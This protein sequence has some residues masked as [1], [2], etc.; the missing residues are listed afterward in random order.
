M[1]NCISYLI[2]ISAFIFCLLLFNLA[3]GTDNGNAPIGAT[4]VMRGIS[5]M[6]LAF[7]ENMG[8]WPDSILFRANANGVTMWFT[9]TGGYH[10]FIRYLPSNGRD[11]T[12]FPIPVKFQDPD[13]R[14]SV[15]MFMVKK[16][17][18]GTNLNSVVTGK[19]LMDYKCNY[20]LGNDPAKWRTDVPNYKEIRLADVYSGIDLRFYGNGRQME[21][22][23]EVAPGADYSQ[24]Q[25]Q[26]EGAKS[27]AVNAA[28]EL[29]IKTEWGN[30]IEQV[31][32]V[33]QII[34]GKKR[35]I[36]GKYCLTSVNTFCFRLD[37]N[38]DPDFEV[39]IDPV[40]IYS[41]YLGGSGVDIIEG[42]AVDSAGC[43]YITGCTGSSDFPTHNPYNGSFNGSFDV[44]VTKLPASGS[45]LM[46]STYLGGGGNDDGYAIAVDSAGCTYLTGTTESPDFPIQNPYDGSYNC[47][48]DAFVVKL[49]VSGG[50]LV[51]STYLGGNNYD[52]CRA[53]AVDTAGC[54]YLTGVTESLDFPIQNAYD[55]IYYGIYYAFIV[56][57]SASG[58][59]LVYSTCLGGYNDGCAIA[60]DNTGCAYL[61]G[62]TQWCSDFP[63][64]NPYEGS[65]NGGYFDA[66]VTKLSA[67]GNALVYSTYL[68]GGV[69]I[70]AM[71]SR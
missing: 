60:V 7:T 5:A 43:V 30:V 55:S 18:L 65:F 24:I 36:S 42:I 14:D 49:A 21:Y 66:F 13:Q 59:E 69:M 28:G 39:V 71:A 51:Y 40:L 9:K 2:R 4:Q 25:F 57:L 53:I 23:F 12:R 1:R 68:G 31:P 33:Y 70:R 27:L 62:E 22:D 16:T 52:V 44:F 8:Q 3:L 17:L 58:G 67:S 20:F 32:I 10:Q 45:A 54:T 35:A 29:V 34:N 41:T 61:T 63:V 64:Q 46:Y 6:P 48:G 19:D 56:K 38:Y 50:A 26:Y 15:E 47:Q 37:I 11:K